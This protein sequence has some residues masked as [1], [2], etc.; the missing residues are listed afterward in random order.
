MLGLYVSDHPL[1]GLDH[2]IRSESSHQILAATPANGV[3]DGGQV[4][5][6]GLVTRVDRRVAKSGNPYAIVTLEDLTGET[7]I[8]F[9]GKTYDTYARDLVDDAVVAIKVR[10]RER[11]DGGL[12]FS[13][14]EPARA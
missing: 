1:S 4:S 10:A 3:S 7:E 11:G 14:V 12:Q 6:A 5:F 9:F 8:S 2:I 13:A